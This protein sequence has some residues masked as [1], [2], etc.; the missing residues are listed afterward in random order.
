MKKIPVHLIT[1]FLGAGKTTFLNH[2]IR[3]RQPERQMIIENEVG[4]TNI[5][6]KLVVGADLNVVELTACR[7]ERLAEGL[8]NREARG[9]FASPDAMEP[10]APGGGVIAAMRGLSQLGEGVGDRR[11]PGREFTPPERDEATTGCVSFDVGVP[12]VPVAIAVHESGVDRTERHQ[13]LR[14]PAMA[15]QSRVEQIEDGLLGVEGRNDRVGD[16][17]ERGGVVAL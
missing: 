14:L 11:S 15:E 13:P 6:S 8:V 5:D 9:L 16:I 4:K 7:V 2:L 3:S 12:C 10:G 1:G 17:G